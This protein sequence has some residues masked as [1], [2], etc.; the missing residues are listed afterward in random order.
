MLFAAALLAL[1]HFSFALPPTSYK[2]SPDAGYPQKVTLKWP[3]P[4]SYDAIFQRS[5]G[6]IY[7]FKGAQYWRVLDKYLSDDLTADTV[8]GVSYPKSIKDNWGI[9]DSNF[10]SV[11]QRPNGKIYF[12]KGDKYWRVSDKY[13]GDGDTSLADKVDAGYPKLISENWFG[14]PNSIDSVIQRSNGLI[15]FFKGDNYYRIRDKNLYDLADDRVE[16]GYPKSVTSNFGVPAGAGLDTG[17]VRSSSAGYIYL[18]KG[19]DYWRI[20]DKYTLS[21]FNDQ[22]DGDLQ[23][24][25]SK[26]GGAATCSPKVSMPNPDA[27]F[28]RKNG[29]IYFFSGTQYW[30]VTDKYLNDATDDCVD[31]GYP[32]VISEQFKGVPSTVDAVFSRDNGKMYFIKGNQYYRVT[33]KY[34]DPTVTVDAVDTGYP[35]PLTGLGL[36]ADVTSVQGVFQR[37][38]GK[39]Y[40]FTSDGK[41]YRVTDKYLVGA[42]EDKVDG[43]YPKDTSDN[44]EGITGS[45]SDVFQ[46]ME[47]NNR[48]YFFT[49]STYGRMA[50]KYLDIG[51]SCCPPANVL[52]PR[53]VPAENPPPPPPGGDDDDDDDVDDDDGNSVSQLMVSFTLMLCAIFAHFH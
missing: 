50:D 7:I 11:F 17:F 38:N 15:Y 21:S 8:D 10:D 9:D 3:V 5:N 29:K 1:V 51:G 43:G 2:D 28:Q 16:C 14:V 49:G 19:A 24:F 48:L 27:A 22:L 4:E 47:S 12:F 31:S 45:I 25:S 41:Y 18:F 40:Y 13:L 46:R 36:P 20:T 44:F 53:T 37:A 26:W 6:K 39:I 52:N 32:K 42:S 23:T 35:K 30:R 33:D 34:L